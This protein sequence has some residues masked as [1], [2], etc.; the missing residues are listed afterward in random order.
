MANTIYPDQI[1]GLKI[2]DS[3]SQA[4]QLCRPHQTALKEEIAADVNDLVRSQF[5]QDK[6]RTLY[7]ADRTGAHFNIRLT[8]HSLIVQLVRENGSHLT[9]EGQ[10]LTVDL[11][12]PGNADII[13]I[14]QSIIDR[15]DDIYQEC[16][17][18]R[19]R[20]H[21]THSTHTFRNRDVRDLS[22][23]PTDD[24]Y[25]E[26]DSRRSYRPRDLSRIS[27]DELLDELDARARSRRSDARYDRE[28]SANRSYRPDSRRRQERVAQRRPQSSSEALRRV[29]ELQLDLKQQANGLFD[30]PNASIDQLAR[31]QEQIG[32]LEQEI[33][34]LSEQLGTLPVTT[35]TMST[36]ATPALQR[37]SERLEHIEDRLNQLAVP[38]STITPTTA[39]QERHDRTAQIDPAIAPNAAVDSE[40][41]LL[42]TLPHLSTDEFDT[43]TQLAYDF[44]AE[45]VR[46]NIDFPFTKD[47]QFLQFSEP[48]R[49]SIYF[50]MYTLCN[51]TR[52]TDT[53][54][55]GEKVF[56]NLDGNGSNNHLRSLAINRYLLQSLANEFA[57]LG[58]AQ[59]P[60]RELLSRFNKLK[61]IDQV[62]VLRQF[63]FLRQ[64]SHDDLNETLNSFL[65][66]GSEPASNEERNE[67]ISR[68]L[69]EQLVYRYGSELSSIFEDLVSLE[70]DLEETRRQMQEERDQHRLDMQRLRLE[71]EQRLLRAQSTLTI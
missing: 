60:S 15:A 19:S 8:D 69:Q 32:R 50:Q 53:W 51:P 41:P 4:L 48:L 11:N 1:R 13:A 43:L 45:D 62:G 21:D 37:I 30:S 63:Q 47:T 29:R 67:S 18:E 61:Q 46:E 57:V 31:L 40:H 65:G 56:M 25:D 42:P 12:A 10:A 49:N 71:T 23:I 39:T 68:Y 24:I 44:D 6:F 33:Q 58:K 28:Y 64:R 14:N 35:G 22:R 5:F 7:P 54:R 36:D 17:N 38:Q 52:A 9:P 26:L 2:Y 55:C 3:E 59:E 27:S 34:R 16:Q 70:L 20:S 66:Q